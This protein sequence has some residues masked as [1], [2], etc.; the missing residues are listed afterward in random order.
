MEVIDLQKWHLSEKKQ[1]GGAVDLGSGTSNFCVPL[2][3]VYSL[4]FEACHVF[5][6]TLYEI[7][8]PQ[9][10]PLTATAVSFLT[11]AK[12]ISRS[13]PAMASDFALLV[14]S[15]SDE[16]TITVGIRCFCCIV[17]IVFHPGEG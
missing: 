3:G 16:R 11:T 9:E 7:S 13:S 5:D 12:I 10:S 4:S 15:A 1:L 8:V 6:H 14:K 2:A 17:M